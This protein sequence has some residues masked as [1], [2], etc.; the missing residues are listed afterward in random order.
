MRPSGISLSRLHRRALYGV[1]A[2]LFLTG[3]AWYLLDNGLGVVGVR[4]SDP[5][6]AIQS[7]LLKVHGAAAMLALIVLGSL[8]PYHVKWAWKVGLNRGTGGLMLSTQ[9]L[10]IV[11]GYAL[12]YSGDEDVRAFA[13][14]LHLII[15]LGFP[16]ILGWHIAEGRRRMQSTRRVFTKGLRGQDVGAPVGSTLVYRADWDETE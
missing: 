12:Y 14:N 8:V 11:T 3:V 4:D 9:V 7:M 2:V 1:F 13:G 15:G 16:V 6:R 5:S 10:L